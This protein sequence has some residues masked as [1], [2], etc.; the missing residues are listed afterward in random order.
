MCVCSPLHRI[1]YMVYRTPP[2]EPPE[3]TTVTQIRSGLTMAP[4][5]VRENDAMRPHSTFRSLVYV[6]PISW[7]FS[8]C[9]S[10][11]HATLSEPPSPHR[12]P[13]PQP[14]TTT[15]FASCYVSPPTNQ[16]TNRPTNFTLA[17]KGPRRRC[18]LRRLLR[19][20]SS[21]K[22]SIYPSHTTAGVRS[23]PTELL[24]LK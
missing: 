16:P 20:L 6:Y 10:N 14:P 5:N 15:V 4:P 8:S 23:H 24:L 21:S 13:P 2:P 9:A 3:Y 1:F 7:F 12:P 19:R 22:F 11:Y 18:P 17:R